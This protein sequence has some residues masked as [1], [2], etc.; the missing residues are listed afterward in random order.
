[1]LDSNFF[2][3]TSNVLPTLE[4]YYQWDGFNG[5]EFVSSTNNVFVDLNKDGFPDPIFHFWSGQNNENAGA[6]VTSGLPNRLVGF[7]LWSAKQIKKNST[8]Q[9]TLPRYIQNNACLLNS[10]TAAINK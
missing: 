2:Q 4:P 9:Y 3:K 10:A 1:M 6:F 7:S 5:Q 8:C